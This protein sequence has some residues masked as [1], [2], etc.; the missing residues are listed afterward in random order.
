MGQT[1]RARRPGCLWPSAS[2]LPCFTPNPALPH[3]VLTF[4]CCQSPWILSKDGGRWLLLFWYWREQKRGYFLCIQAMS[5]ACSPGSLHS[6]CIS[7]FVLMASICP[8][9]GIEGSVGTLE[10]QRDFCSK[11]SRCDDNHCHLKSSEA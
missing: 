7:G 2:C 4:S 5:G 8:E 9:S 3:L 10:P 11:E 1:R 6:R